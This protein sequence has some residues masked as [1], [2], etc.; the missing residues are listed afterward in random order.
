MKAVLFDLDGTLVDHDSA[1]VTA[2]TRSY[3]GLREADRAHALRRWRQLEP[4]MERYLSGELTFTG[5]RRLRVTSL[6]AE[7]GLGA[8]DAARA[9]AW[10]AGYLRHYE[11]AWRI[12][13]D[14]RP[15]LDTLAEHHRHLRLGVLTNGDGV[16]QGRKLLHVGLAADLPAVIAAGDVGAAK[17]DAEI[18]RRAARGSGSTGAR[19]PTSGTGSGLTRSPPRTP[20]CAGSG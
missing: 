19:W 12:Y 3:P 15:V 11:S 7:L 13:P 5:Q 8:W 4:A 6:A 2:L 14:V 10:F 18:F 16:Q 20:G 1:T 17:P 9:D